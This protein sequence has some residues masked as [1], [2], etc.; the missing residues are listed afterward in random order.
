MKYCF[1]LANKV[2]TKLLLFTDKEMRTKPNNIIFVNK[3][4]DNTSSI[5]EIKTQV[6]SF[7]NIRE[8]GFLFSNKTNSLN[9]FPTLKLNA[10]SKFKSQKKP[11]INSKFQSSKNLLVD[12]KI[13][14]VF[15]KNQKYFNQNYKKQNKKMTFNKCNK[16][17]K[18][19][20]K[21]YLKKLCRNL[22]NKPKL[23][24]YYHSKPKI[25]KK[26]IKSKELK[27][28]VENKKLL[29]NIGS[30]KIILFA[31]DACEY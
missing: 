7:S 10:Y 25:P 30:F 16:N 22:V 14:D 28:N 29:N 8:H 11:N 4:K 19:N 5:C 3:N 20:S 23:N 15:S 9:S 27:K 17:K 31:C 21:E 13:S 12:L 6:E 26:S 18:R 24:K 1:S 2:R